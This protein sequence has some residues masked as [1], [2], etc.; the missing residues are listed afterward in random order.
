M[1]TSQ[2]G[3]SHRRLLTTL[4]C[5]ALHLFAAT[6]NAQLYVPPDF[7]GDGEAGSLC[8]RQNLGQ[9][10]DTNGNQPTDIAYYAER[11]PVGIYLKEKNEV[12]FT[13]AALHNDS[14]IEDTLYR[15]DML[16]EG[17]REQDPVA[18]SPTP[19]IANYYL[20]SFTAEDVPA[21]HRVVYQS[22]WDSIDVHFYHG[23]SGPR[24]SFV[25]R[26]GGDPDEI[27]L[28]FTGQDSLNVDVAGALKLYLRNQWFRFEEAKAYQV[29][30]SGPGGLGTITSVPWNASYLNEDSTIYVKFNHGTYNPAKALIFQ[31]GYPPMM[32]GGG[33]NNFCWSTHFGGF[34]NAAMATDV[35]DD[36]ELYVAGSTITDL[37]P[38]TV[39]ATVNPG[40]FSSSGTLAKFNSAYQIVWATYYGGETDE[41]FQDIAYSAYGNYVFGVGDTYSSDL[42]TPYSSGE[43]HDGSLN[44][45]NNTADAFM[46]RF[47]AA[48]GALEWGTYYGGIG[49]DRA[50]S[51]VCDA[52]GAQYVLGFGSDELDLQ[53]WGTAYFQS[54]AGVE[55]DP[56]ATPDAFIA[57]FDNA[58]TLIWSTYVGGASGDG[59]RAA[60]LDENGNVFVLGSAG[61]LFPQVN[62]CGSLVNT[63]Y[64]G[65]ASDC[66]LLKFDSTGDLCWS[67]YAGGIGNDAPSVEGGVAVGNE[68]VYFG[69][70]SSST[71][72]PTLELQG[73]YYQEDNAGGLD[74]VLMGFDLSTLS[75]IWS[76]YV[77]GTE[78]DQISGI[79]TDTWGNLFLAGFSQSDDMPLVELTAAYYQEYA[80]SGPNA[81]YGDAFVGA[82]TYPEHSCKW[83]TMVGGGG[84]NNGT[85][86]GAESIVVDGHARIFIAGTATSEFPP[87]PTH[88]PGN[89]AYFGPTAMTGSSA[90]TCFDLSAVPVSV[91]EAVA[92]NEMGFVLVPNADH[93]VI[94]AFVQ[95]SCAR[96][97]QLFDVSGRT[98]STFNLADG[99]QNF[100]IPI[101]RLSS[102]AYMVCIHGGDS[103]AVTARF[104]KP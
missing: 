92:I 48:S 85:S 73:G 93:S 11:S 50:Y 72:F 3:L 91:A 32:L 59:F 22:V 55:S 100:E 9:V 60:A 82:Y 87:Y 75:L 28:S 86:D 70:N 33:S 43:Y 47:N 80:G 58:Q 6:S 95:P 52:D 14:L 29:N 104:V 1:K 84:P 68:R 67:T 10:F 42:P 24:V 101:V 63:Q 98:V 78:R 15:V 102:G 74:G 13:L 103:N 56:F 51:V 7:W 40:P 83:F 12:S 62:T 94:S 44:G 90:I 49:D 25:V 31:I 65:G 19:D 37:F 18:F 41:G 89:G 64:G 27:L 26:P 23:S 46:C 96:V 57:R 34:G 71:N 99:V 35:D 36:G 66:V 81:F 76:T 79:D 20:G 97:V 21:S 4:Y 54:F 77:G 2:L 38:A 61:S 16:L 5:L 88:D 30:T 8:Y 45:N 17:T 53:G 69:A 39:G